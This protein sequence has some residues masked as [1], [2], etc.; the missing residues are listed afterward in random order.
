MKHVHGQSQSINRTLQDQSAITSTS[1][2]C[3]CPFVYRGLQ[4]ES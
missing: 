3:F 4:I 2:T 1:S